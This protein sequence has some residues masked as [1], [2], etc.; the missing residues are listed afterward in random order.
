MAVVSIPKGISAEAW[1]E[2]VARASGDR[3]RLA[4]LVANGKVG[5]VK[6][7][8]QLPIPNL[9]DRGSDTIRPNRKN[10]RK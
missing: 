10:K 9:N 1:N 4:R 2:A 5:R 3:V 7:V 6:G 8:W